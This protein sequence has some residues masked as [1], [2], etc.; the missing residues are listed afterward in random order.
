MGEKIFSVKSFNPYEY[1]FPNRNV[2]TV[3]EIH[4]IKELKQLGYKVNILLDDP[5]PVDYLF[6]KGD[7]AVFDFVWPFILNIFQELPK[8]IVLSG[9]AGWYIRTFFS[10]DDSKSIPDNIAKNIICIENFSGNMYNLA[11]DTVSPGDIAKKWIDIENLQKSYKQSF[12]QQSSYDDLTTP[13]YREH[14]PK[15]VG[16]AKISINNIGMHIDKSI[17]TDKQTWQDILAKKLRSFS[18]AGIATKSICSI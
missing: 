14:S 4:L 17:I 13:I 8:G 2:L 5:R 18:A 11:G 9:I 1:K 12:I 3:T 15:I 6:R 16:W 10:G 7:Q